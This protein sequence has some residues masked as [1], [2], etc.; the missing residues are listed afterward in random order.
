[1]VLAKLV[2]AARVAALRLRG[3]RLGC[4]AQVGRGVRCGGNVQIGENSCVGDDVVL[5]GNV[6]I[7]RGVRICKHVELHGNIMIDD[8]SVV[9]TFS[10]LST[11]PG[12]ELTI[13]KDV[14]VNSFSVIGAVQQVAIADHCIF[15]AFVHITDA[16][17][18]F[19]DAAT[20]I[21]HAPIRSRPVRIGRDVWL[22]SGVMVTMGVSIGDGAV[23]GAK[24]LV[25][26]D[27]P[28]MSVAFG[29]PA[30]VVRS[31]VSDKME[32]A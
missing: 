3:A 31:R 18:E 12:G 5:N 26:R 2:N 30:R 23:I 17:H 28:A 19:G 6:K 7:G 10:I 14:Y 4:G 11:L 24:A 27:V 20:P 22:G 25:T 29:V 15:A 21:K 32:K 16:T 8:D 1:M 9:G 13:G